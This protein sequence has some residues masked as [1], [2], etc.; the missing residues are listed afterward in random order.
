M[1]HVKY[2]FYSCQYGGKDIPREV[3]DGFARRAG[4][5]LEN[6][7]RVKPDTLDSEKIQQVLCEICDQLYREDRRNGIRQENLDGYS[8]TYDESGAESEILRLV[9]RHLGD[10]GVLYRGRLS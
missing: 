3:F 5:L 6:M 7:L 9:R 2:D 8:V 4:I 10:S 1:V